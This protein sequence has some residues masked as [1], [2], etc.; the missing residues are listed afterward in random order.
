M[1]ADRILESVRRHY[2]NEA[3]GL[4][5]NDFARK[6]YSE[7]TQSLALIIEPDSR[8]AETFSHVSGLA[9]CSIYFSFYYLDACYRNQ[10]AGLF[11]KRLERYFDLEKEGLRTLPEEFHNPRSDCHAWS[12][13]VLYHYFAS[14]LGIRPTAFGR[15]KI[16]IRPMKG[17]LSFA[18]GKSPVLP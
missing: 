16:E 17:P 11:F 2:W 3:R 5:A 12:S 1:L 14:I 13:H 6:Y 7:H 10:L 9:E 8:L 15:R 4:Y 18:E